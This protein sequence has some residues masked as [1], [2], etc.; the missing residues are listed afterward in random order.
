MKFFYS[1]LVLLFSVSS[2]AE[3]TNYLLDTGDI[4]QITVYGE[5]ELSLETKISRSGKLNYPFLGEMKINGLTENALQDKIYRGLK[6]NYLIEPTVNVTVTQYRPFFIHG[7]V[8]TPGSYPY[9]PGMTVNQ[10]IAIAGGLTERASKDKIFLFREK[11]KSQQI[12]ATL[13]STV[14]AGDTLTV[15]QRFF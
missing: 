8:Q 6:G 1:L 13:N 12:D 10:A 9:Q 2:F 5:D 3:Q 11:N 4:I 7:E 15:E 14:N